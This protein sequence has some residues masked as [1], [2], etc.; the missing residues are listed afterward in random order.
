[1]RQPGVPRRQWQRELR[2]DLSVVSRAGA[3][4]GWV[5]TSWVPPGGL[6][7]I[8]KFLGE[9]TVRSKERG[10]Q[11]AGSLA[12]GSFHSPLVIAFNALLLCAVGTQSAL[13]GA[14]VPSVP[15]LSWR[16]M[17]LQPCRYSSVGVGRHWPQEH[18]GDREAGTYY[19][20]GRGSSQ[21]L[22]PTNWSVP[23]TPHAPYTL[24]YIDRLFHW[25]RFDFW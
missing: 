3:A 2:E 15:L 14:P 18:C 25:F 24:Y 4:H 21:A 1:M 17:G 16:M 20:F 7:Q 9:D 13:L 6:G 23:V 22:M 19:R 10:R 11:G 5:P 8:R 12:S